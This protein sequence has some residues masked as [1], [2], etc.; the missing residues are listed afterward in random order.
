MYNFLQLITMNLI[1]KLI[2]IKKVNF[3]LLINLK[4]YYIYI[5]MYKHMVT[6]IKMTLLSSILH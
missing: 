5:E 4:K 1:Y 3:I 2:A 6:K